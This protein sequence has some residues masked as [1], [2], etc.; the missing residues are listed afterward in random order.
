MN[1]QRIPNLLTKLLSDYVS[2][3]CRKKYYVKC[4]VGLYTKSLLSVNNN[5][6][7]V[8]VIFPQCDPLLSMCACLFK[9]SLF[10][11]LTLI[12][13]QENFM[14]TKSYCPHRK[15]C[16]STL[17]GSWNFYWCFSHARYS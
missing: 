14:D 13:L 8:H 1:V 16:F 3:T 15:P 7:I 11:F 6:A 10:L 4:D 12:T 17:F 2:V 9:I 5:C